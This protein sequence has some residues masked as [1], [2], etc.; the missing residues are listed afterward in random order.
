MSF[1][2]VLAEYFAPSVYNSLV[3]TAGVELGFHPQLEVLG[4]GVSWHRAGL[5]S[6]PDQHAAVLEAERAIYPDGLGMTEVRTWQTADEN[7]A[8][9]EWR[10]AGRT[11]NGRDV[12]NGGLSVFEFEDG[13]VR[14]VRT[15]T[16]T[17]YLQAIQQGWT[18]LLSFDTLLHVPAFHTM[19]LPIELSKPYPPAPGAQTEDDPPLV[20]PEP[21]TNEQRIALMYDPPVF[22]LHDTER[23]ARYLSAYS[24]DMYY[25]WQGTRW[26][27]AGRNYRR[28]QLAAAERGDVSEFVV[29]TWLRFS[30]VK[31]WATVDQRSV[32][33]EWVSK[34]TMWT[35]ADFRNHGMTLLQFDDENRIVAHREYNNCAYNEASEGDWR[36]Q[37]EPAA[38]N[39][40]ALSKTWDLPSEE[41]KPI[42]IHEAEASVR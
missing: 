25:E 34:S 4:Q 36:D 12:A 30:H 35:G 13:L 41:W 18:E 40:R 38:F 29:H 6:T 10:D 1:A 3:P 8:F 2:D 11:W 14:R 5:A 23:R 39:A 32:F 28:D 7:A 22:D 21:W 19:G 33:M 27:M 37:M 24:P 26:M 31:T 15:F 17:S 9:V 20:F 42:P 16:N